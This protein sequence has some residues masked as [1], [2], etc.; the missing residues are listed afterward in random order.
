MTCPIDAVSGQDVL[1]ATPLCNLSF[2]DRTLIAARSLIALWMFGD[3]D[4]FG[5]FLNG[6]VCS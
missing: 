3:V 2:L 6:L 5:S 1:Q 4:V